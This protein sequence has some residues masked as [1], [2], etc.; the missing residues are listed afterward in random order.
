[1]AYIPPMEYTRPLYLTSPQMNGDD[2]RVVQSELNGLE[3]PVGTIDGWFGS[4]SD[5]AVKMFQAMND[6]TIDGSVGPT[7]WNRL[8]STNAKSLIRTRT[9]YLT[10]PQKSGNDV[11]AVQL[12]LTNLGYDLGTID[13]YFGRKTYGAIIAFQSVNNIEIDGS[14][15]PQTW[16]TLFDN[17]AKSYPTGPST[18]T[19]FYCSPSKAEELGYTITKTEYLLNEHAKILRD[20]YQR[21]GEGYETTNS[22]VLGILGSYIKGMITGIGYTISSILGFT[23]TETKFEQL[24]ND[25]YQIATSGSMINKVRCTYKYNRLGSYDGAYFL[26]DI[27]LLEE[28]EN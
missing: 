22:I 7:T 3:Y 28:D 24:E 10:S 2:V 6:L 21:L 8:F 4:K 26:S 17:A 5:S 14:C 23:V 15:G 9:L 25:F 27:E 11:M 1:M 20:E 19:C 16:S 18:L 12:R 13:G